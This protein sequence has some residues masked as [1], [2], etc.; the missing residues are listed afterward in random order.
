MYFGFKFEVKELL[1]TLRL[2]EQVVV[3][4]L[5]GY[6]L[7]FSP[8]TPSLSSVRERMPPNKEIEFKALYN[9]NEMTRNGLIFLE[10][11]GKSCSHLRNLLSRA[12]IKGQ[13]E[14]FPSC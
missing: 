11:E 2:I 6:T 14:L 4:H 3:I 1:P 9:F 5:V 8:T 7:F 10:I 12:Y 13:Q